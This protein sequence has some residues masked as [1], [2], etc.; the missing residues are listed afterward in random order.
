MF[1]LK[2]EATTGKVLQ[3]TNVESDYQVVNIDGLNPPNAT[4]ISSNVAGVDG[5][6]FRF[7]KLMERNIV[8]TLRINGDVE[9]N[10][11]NLYR[12]FRTKQWCKIYYT[13]EY[14]DI[15]IEGYVENIDCNLFTR[16]ELMQISIVCHDPYFKSVNEIINDISKVLGKF[17]FPFAIETPIEFSTYDYEKI[18]EV[19]NDSEVDIGLIIEITFEGF[20]E[21]PTIKDVTNGNEFKIY[22]EFNAGDKIII[23]TNRGQKSV[24]L[25]RNTIEENIIGSLGI[26]SVWFKLNVGSNYFTYFAR[27]GDFFMRVIYKHNNLFEG[28]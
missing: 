3:L 27:R 10:R 25:I 20:T 11:L 19:V 9:K 8:I 22:G 18:I 5:S 16:S 15:Y 24:K 28:V 1:T 21:D 14:R 7:S 26:G 23:N 2:V 4:I 13:N 6:R 12:Y 17:E